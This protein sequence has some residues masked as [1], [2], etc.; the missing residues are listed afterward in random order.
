MSSKFHAI[1]TIVNT[2]Q[3][4]AVFEQLRLLYLHKIQNKRKQKG[5]MIELRQYRKDPNLT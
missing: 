5:I 2:A 1:R 3:L 4:L